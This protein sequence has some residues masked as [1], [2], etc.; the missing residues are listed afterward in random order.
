MN[1]LSQNAMTRFTTTERTLLSLLSSALFGTP[2]HLPD[3]VNWGEVVK[4]AKA[5]AVLPL[6]LHQCAA[7]PPEL[8]PAV[9]KEI[10]QILAANMV[11][12]WN[13]LYIHDL[14]T[15]GQIPYVILKGCASAR[16]YP[17][18]IYRTMGDVDFLVSP[19]NLERADQIL[20]REQLVP[21]DQDH[22]CHI[23]YT[24][25]RMHL[26]L[27]FAPAGIPDGEAGE[28]VRS[29]LTDIFDRSLETKA[30]DGTLSVPDDF[31]H[32]LI[33]LLHTCHHLTVEGI[34]LRHLC[35]WA[36][37]VNHLGDAFPT[38]FEE[39]LKA[40]GL[41]RFAQLLCRLSADYL[42]M[43]VRPWLQKEE[44]EP[45]LTAMMR[46]IFDGGNFG[47]K[48]RGRMYENMMIANKGENWS[49]S[50]S[51]FRQFFISMNQMVEGNW[52]ICKKV[53]ILY[54]VGW[55][56]LG[57]RRVIRVLLGKRQRIHLTRMVS[58]VKERT[59]MYQSFHLYEP[60]P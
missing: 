20:R 31:H 35:D 26:E 34:G 9:Q 52:P 14:M 11:V 30:G 46:D 48:D 4:E 1:Y 50:T 28:L 23:V 8:K 27:H 39:K 19:E 5:Q 55:L 40:I 54:P 7:L 41:W 38:L 37:F 24:K 6:A 25:P 32:G 60:E 15:S 33:L 21:W 51:M 59:E 43:P 44:D 53:K 58:D 16:Y 49:G 22:V 10:R 57:L 36:V 13:H 45:L 12:E 47:V 56:F 17:E 2:I 42:G 18:P 3:E 29:Y